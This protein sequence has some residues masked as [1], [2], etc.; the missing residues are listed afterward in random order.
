MKIKNI[1]TKPIKVPTKNSTG[2][3]EFILEVGQIA[4][5]DDKRKKDNQIIIWEKKKA[6]LVERNAVKPEN[7]EYN[8]AYSVFINGI[9]K[10]SP[11][12]NTINMIDLDDDLEGD[13][14]APPDDDIIAEVESEDDEPLTEKN[15]TPVKN[16]GGRPKG[17]K[18]KKKKKKS[19]NKKSTSDIS[20][21]HSDYPG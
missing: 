15:D 16:K 18:N 21:N 6:I 1:S 10:I 12:P 20:I 5:L 11:A 9:H 17:A 14:I 19:K 4:Y 7:L 2:K 13:D 8:R 3:K